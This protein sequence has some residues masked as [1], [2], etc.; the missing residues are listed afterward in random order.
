MP[1]YTYECSLCR[2]RQT[3]VRSIDHRDDTAF[4]MAVGETYMALCR[5]QL[6]RVADAPA[7]TVRGYNA[8]NGYSK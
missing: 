8:K 1:T 5:G 6:Q 7:F 3:R 4:C 2:R